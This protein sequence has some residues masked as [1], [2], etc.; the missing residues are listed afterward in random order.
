[1]LYHVSSF[2]IHDEKLVYGE[3][4]D[5]EYAQYTVA[6]FKEKVLEY[7]KKRAEG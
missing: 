1:V 2:P 3:T 7:A 6:E 4:S 5:S